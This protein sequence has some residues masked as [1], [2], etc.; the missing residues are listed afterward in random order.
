MKAILEYLVRE[1]VDNPKEVKVEEEKQPQA[2]LLKLS[3]A[4]ED[5]AKVIGKNGKIIKSL[6]TILRISAIKTG[7]TVYIQILDEK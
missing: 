6:R 4:K 3:V 5:I 2:S 1:F 7:E